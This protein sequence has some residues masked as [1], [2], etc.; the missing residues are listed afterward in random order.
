[1]KSLRRNFLADVQNIKKTAERTVRFSENRS[2][3]VFFA[4][5]KKS[6]R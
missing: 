5:S 1:M 3:A 4:V 2:R 6:R